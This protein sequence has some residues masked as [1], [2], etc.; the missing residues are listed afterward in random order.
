MLLYVDNK[1]NLLGGSVIAPNAGEMFQELV[2]AKANKLKINAFFNKIYSYPTS[3]RVN[4]KI[5]GNLMSEKL[6]PFIKGLLRF[7]Y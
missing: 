4:K 2:L 1:N 6:T 7:L 3:T 5:I